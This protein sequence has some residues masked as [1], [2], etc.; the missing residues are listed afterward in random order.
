MDNTV[1]YMYVF[2]VA[3]YKYSAQI[4]ILALI[5]EKKH[6]SVFIPNNI[7]LHD[8]KDKPTN[9]PILNMSL[10]M[11]FLHSRLDFFPLKCGAV[12]DEH[13][14]HFHQDIQAMEQSYE[15]TWSAAMLA[16][17]CWVVKR[18]AREC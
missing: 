5:F 6:F 9:I 12:S 14:E 1:L 10:E 11:H 17:Y 7:N 13:G 2:W 4:D 3:E 15:S 18:G 8:T 16:D